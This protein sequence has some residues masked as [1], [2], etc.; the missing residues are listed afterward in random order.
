[1][2]LQ[3]PFGFFLSFSLSFFLQATKYDLHCVL[4]NNFSQAM[5]K[6]SNKK[7]KKKNNYKKKKKK[8]S[9]Q[10]I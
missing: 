5:V 10:Y 3:F 7:K 2:F 6:N 4:E 1:M 8:K 9:E